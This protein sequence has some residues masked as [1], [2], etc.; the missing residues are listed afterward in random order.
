MLNKRKAI[1]SS[2]LLMSLIASACSSTGGDKSPADES[3]GKTNQPV[4]KKEPAEIVFYSLAGDQEAAFNLKYGDDLRKKFPDYTFKFIQNKEGARIPDLLATKERID[5]IY[6]F[7]EDILTALTQNGIQFEMSDLAKKHNIDVGKLDQAII[8]GFR[9]SSEGKLYVLPIHNATQVLYY[10]KDLFNKFGVGFP[11]DGMTWSELTD[12]AKKLTRSD[13]GVQYFGFAGYVPYLLKT[14]PFS[15]PYLDPKT[16]KPTFEKDAWK[17]VV[18]ENMINPVSD[19]GYLEWIQK[20]KR[21]PNRINFHDT[22]EVAILHFHSDLAQALPEQF[23]KLN[24]DY[25]ALPTFKEMPGIGA[26]PSPQSMA[27]TSQAANKDAAMEVLQFLTSAEYQKML[28]R[29][30]KIP[31]LT[32]VMNDAAVQKT[33]G[34]DTPFKDKNWGAFFYNKSAQLAPRTPYEGIVERVYEKVMNKTLID[35]QDLNTALRELNEE[36]NKTV[37]AAKA[38]AGK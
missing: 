28:A 10:N 19:A 8:Q 18:Q 34:Q 27:I 11:K 20:N 24:W 32:E 14:N 15:E 23:G 21:L 12:L 1:T 16:G 26:Q 5:I 2:V 13:G 17:K 25:A 3:A 38:A 7:F 33:F 6:H 29:R 36:A 9:N 30:G 35:K 22:L 4:Q 31:V 37:E